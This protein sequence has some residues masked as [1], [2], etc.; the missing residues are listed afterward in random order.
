MTYRR[1][2]DKPIVVKKYANRRLY[3]TGRSS[4]VTLDDLC[5]MVKEQLDFVV[6]DAKTNEDL[7]QQ[8]LTQIIV[9]QEQKEGQNLLPLNFLKQLISFYGDGMQAIVPNY[10]EQ[11]ISTFT[12]N[13]EKFRDQI[14]KSLGGMFPI[15]AFEEM[16]RQN[17]AM[18][19]NAMK[20]FNPFRVGEP[21]LTPAIRKKRIEELKKGITDMQ[22]ELERLI[23]IGS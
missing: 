1:H 8:V 10:L 20:A 21:P 15:N 13:Q 11:S 7:T 23:R 12:S 17:M 2:Q 4:Y 3:D 16:N 19:E 14:N 9:E 18:F 6:V 22:K 5:E